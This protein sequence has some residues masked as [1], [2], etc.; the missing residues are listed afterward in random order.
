MSK[1]FVIIS[2]FLFSCSQNTLLTVKLSELEMYEVNERHTGVILL[3]SFILNKECK[4][5]D[6]ILYANVFL[7]QTN[8]SSDT[9]L[10]FS[11]CKRAYEFLHS[12]YRDE[13]DLTI[14]S[15]T[16]VKSIPELLK[17]NVDSS[18]LN[19][20]YKFI[21]GDITKLEY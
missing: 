1:I 3:K 6:D 12:N 8:V 18:I 4:K 21:I 7:C 10:V 15:F 5:D 14:D 19:K 17:V 11:I 2:M 16:I 13:R 20:K 9:I